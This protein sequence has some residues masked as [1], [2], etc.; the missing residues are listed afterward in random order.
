MAAEMQANVQ[1]QT[2]SAFSEQIWWE[3]LQNFEIKDSKMINTLL[4]VA[5]N[6]QTRG[7]GHVGICK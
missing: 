5:N 2:E 7:R 1:D 6:K 3:N 4:L